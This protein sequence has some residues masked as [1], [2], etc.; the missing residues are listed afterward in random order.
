MPDFSF[1]RFVNVAKWDVTV[2]RKYYLR[3]GLTLMLIT[4]IPVLTNVIGMLAN[5]LGITQDMLVAVDDMLPFEASFFFGMVM[6][7]MG[8]TF[9]N[10][11]NKGSRLNEL[12]LPATSCEKFL[13]HVLFYLVF[14]VLVFMLGILVSDMVNAAFVSMLV[15]SDSVHSL[16]LV[17]LKH[18]G[19][20]SVN[21]VDSPV[22]T[23][24]ICMLQ[25]GALLLILSFYSV[26]VLVNAWKYRYNIPLT[27]L[28]H[29]AV[30]LL[31]AFAIGM[32]VQYLDEWIPNHFLRDNP[33]LL[34]FLAIVLDAVSA[35]VFVGTWWLSYRL[36][37]RA[38]ITTR[39]NP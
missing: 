30:C 13:W 34:T 25:V 38:Q 28:L 2:N 7:M 32:S 19:Y 24:Q 23:C 27:M 21:V 37:R 14:P 8:H 33:N 12:M 16:T 6:M 36:Y 18:L 20:V 15:G 1:S 5:V 9:H 26:F 10:F 29:A 31:M 11:L 22:T 35:L 4:S 39:R 17:V 3:L